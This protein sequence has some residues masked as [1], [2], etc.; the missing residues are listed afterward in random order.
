VSKYCLEQYGSTNLIFNSDRNYQWDG[1]K[2]DIR[3]FGYPMR[4]VVA[5]L[6]LCDLVVGVDTGPM[7]TAAAL[8]NKAIWLFTHIDGK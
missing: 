7:H 5:L 2:E 1:Y 8:G 3:V 6:S 4:K